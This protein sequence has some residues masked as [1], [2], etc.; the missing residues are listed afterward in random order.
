MHNIDVDIVRIRRNAQYRS[1]DRM[2]ILN[3]TEVNDLSLRSRPIDE[4]T[5]YHAFAT[6][7]AQHPYGEARLPLWF[8]IGIKSAKAEEHFEQN[9]K[10]E[11]GEEVAW[12]QETMMK[13]GVL[14]AICQPASDLVKQMDGVGF[15]NCNGLEPVARA[16]ESSTA[17]ERRQQPGVKLTANNAHEFW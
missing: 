5:A 12:T 14:K 8:E 4:K 11:F 1:T 2:S 9:L 13:A 6:G 17:E 16:V 10:L 7:S 15:W 3:V